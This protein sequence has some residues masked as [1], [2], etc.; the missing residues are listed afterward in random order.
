MLITIIDLEWTTNAINWPWESRDIIE[1]GACQL[2][3]ETDWLVRPAGCVV[4][5][6]TAHISKRCAM[7]TGITRDQAAGGMPFAEACAWLQARY[8]ASD[9]W[10]SF[11]Y[12]DR[13]RLAAQCRREGLPF[14]LTGN[15]ID[16]SRLAAQHVGWWRRRSLVATMAALG[17]KFQGRPHGALADAVNAAKVLRAVL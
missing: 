7:L 6:T 4:I 13:V 17:L 15:H 10:A 2:D 16:I 3:T 8:G 12:K 1:V 14:P 9:A 5:P 11:G